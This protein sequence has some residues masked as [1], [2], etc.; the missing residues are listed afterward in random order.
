MRLKLSDPDSRHNHIGV[1]LRCVGAGIHHNAA[2]IRVFNR[3]GFLTARQWPPSRWWATY[4]GSACP[5]IEFALQFSLQLVETP[6]GTVWI[7]FWRLH[8]IAYFQQFLLQFH[9]D[10]RWQ[11]GCPQ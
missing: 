7:G 9:A 1:I 10:I 3:L 8:C 6:G 5:P 11:P 4:C 2:G